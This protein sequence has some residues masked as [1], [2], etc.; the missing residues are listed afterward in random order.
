MAVK[1][2]FTS[3][4]HI[5]GSRKGDFASSIL[6]LYPTGSAT[7]FALT[8][9]MESAPATDPVVTWFEDTHVTGRQT[10]VTG[11]NS[12][13]TSIVLDGASTYVPGTTLLVEETGEMLYIS[14][15]SSAT[16]TVERGFAGTTAATISTD[17]HVQRIGN[18]F[19][20][21]SSRPVAVANAGVARWNY[22]QI[23]RNSWDVSG[24]A[25][26][27]EYR[28]GDIVAKNKSECMMYHSED[29]ERSLWWGRKTQGTRNGR[30]FRTMDGVL[31]QITTNVTT[32]GST[33]S[34]T[35]FDTF[36][37]GVFSKNVKGKPNE[38]IAFCGNG[39]LGVVQQI[40]V[41]NS[42]VNIDTG[43]TE[44]G[45]EVTKWITPYG[46]ISLMTHP[47]FNEH[48]VWTKNLIV[49][50]PG[51]VRMRYLRRTAPDNYDRDGS[52][53]GVDGD[54]GV[55]TTECTMEYK[56]EQTGGQLLALTAGAAG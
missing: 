17:D 35:Q 21:A 49:L 28:T 10:V 9:G 33:T 38:R 23:F 26:V 34:W 12:A 6:S 25:R 48:P 4:A 27:T 41:K 1:G 42:Q 52:R 22:M 24:T 40:A 54:F 7:L 53:A 16:V 39:A 46:R 36:L 15:V 14:A 50:H 31:A 44:F 56:C 8:S 45:M 32:A 19:E 30:V 47:L 3:D 51:A 11:G 2:V 18:T 37:Q 20:E 13:A 55:L 29:I 5:A 43:A